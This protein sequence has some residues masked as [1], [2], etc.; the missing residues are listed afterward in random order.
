MSSTYVEVMVADATYHGQEALTYY[1]DNIVPIGSIVEVQLK[2]KKVP[3]IVV[4]TTK[5]PAFKVKPVEN[6]IQLPPIPRQLLSL[7]SWMKDYYPG[8]SGILTGLFL[9]PHIPKK[10]STDKNSFASN[11]PIT[12]PPLTND[13]KRA[14]SQ[15]ANP[16]LH[17]LH[18]ETGSGKTRVYMELA[19]KALST[20]KTSIILTPEIGLTS[21]LTSNF[22]AIF[23]ERVILLH[24]QMTDSARYK[25]W[26]GALISKEPLIIIGPRSALFTP[27]KNIG[28]I[29]VDESHEMAYKQD[30]SPYY[31]ASF[32]AAKLAELHKATLVLGSATPSV[33]DYAIA[34][35]RR[36]PIVRMSQTASSSENTDPDIEIVDLKDRSNFGKNSY[37]S[38]PLIK[39]ISNTLARGEQ[40]LIFLNRR[41]TARVIFCE[42]CSWQALCPHC[43]LPLVYHGD[44][45]YMQCHTCARRSPSPICC[46]DC[47]N[48]T[49]VFRG[50]G[51]KAVA[52]TLQKLFTNK[53]IQRFDTDNKKDE[54]IEQHFENVQRGDI[55]IIVG[56]QT[57]AKGIDLPN[58]GLVGVIAADSGLSFPD[59]SAQERTYQLLHQ[60]IGRVGR[61]HRKGKAIIQ[62]YNPD[63]PVLKMVVKKDWRAFSKKELEERKQYKFPPF[64]YLLKLTC[65]RATVQSAQQAAQRLA[66]SLSNQNYKILI[67]GPAPSFY[68]KVQ[69]KF[70]WQLIIKARQRSE[71]IKII[72][73]LPANWSYDIDPLNLL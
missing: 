62:T 69:G 28:L 25:A 39:E 54:R 43:D 61:G 64:Y 2:N 18:G 23:G 59:F 21:Q 48:T 66:D 68:E 46:P 10:I 44:G 14:L 67:E 71:L 42:K 6:V 49:I 9:P 55:D 8:P 45:H 52:E 72:G 24:S 15:L 31:H 1:C 22:K 40:V 29:V 60:V 41:G 32:V 34:E 33:A 70:Q 5:K 20:G 57:I 47:G 3:G 36:R 7:L 63:N 53:K 35:A 50:A 27:V 16:G 13:Q 65:R 4:S 37:L 38:T 26:S 58:L 19:Q 17:I 73:V 12:L 56:T 30:R 11:T 51:T